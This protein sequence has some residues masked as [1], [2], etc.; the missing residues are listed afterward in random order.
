M[1]LRLTFSGTNPYSLERERERV[2]ETQKDYAV[3]EIWQKLCF[4]CRL[5]S[6]VNTTWN[7]ELINLFCWNRS[8]ETQNNTKTSK[9]NLVL[10]AGVEPQTGNSP[11]IFIFKPLFQNIKE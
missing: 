4:C 10:L 6:H 7:S 2:T 9:S 3:F 8:D 11:P 5:L 1:M